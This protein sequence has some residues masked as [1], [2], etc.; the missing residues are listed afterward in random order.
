MEGL[1]DFNFH[2]KALKFRTNLG[3]SGNHPL[4]IHQST[5][6]VNSLTYSP[7]HKATEKQTGKSFSLEFPETGLLQQQMAQTNYLIISSKKMVW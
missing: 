4:V 1:Y 2:H 7:S 5:P 3:L 6:V